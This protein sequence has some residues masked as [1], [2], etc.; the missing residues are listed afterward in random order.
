[1]PLNLID[2]II[3]ARADA[4]KAFNLASE[5]LAKLDSVLDSLH[6]LETYASGLD[7]A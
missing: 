6:M 3:L 4:E 1:M 5:S 7:D 2:Y